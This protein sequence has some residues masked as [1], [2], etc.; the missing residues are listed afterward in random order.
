MADVRIGEPRTYN[1]GNGST[2]VIPIRPPPQ[3]ASSTVRG[4]RDIMRARNERDAKR[5]EEQERIEREGQRARI[6]TQTVE[7]RQKSEAQWLSRPPEYNNNNGAGMRGVPGPANDDGSASILRNIS[8]NAQKEDRRRMSIGPAPRAT[9]GN[10]S[11]EDRSGFSMAQPTRSV[12]ANAAG[13]PQNIIQG[14]GASDVGGP[15]RTKG[16]SK[17]GF[18]LAFERWEELSAHWEG[19][20]SHSLRTIQANL[21]EIESDSISEQ[22]ARQVKDLS[23]AGANL[24]HA[25]VELQRLR[26]SSER[27]FQRWFADTRDEQEKSREITKELE[28]QLQ[29]ERTA[30][31]HTQ[32]KAALETS[33]AEAAELKKQVAEARRELI[34]SRDESRRAWEELGRR[35]QLERERL[36]NLRDGQPTN[37]CGVT[38]VP[39]MDDVPPRRTSI[40]EPAQT[41]ADTSHN[42]RP[43]AREGLYPG[44]PGQSALGGQGMM[45]SP[46][47]GYPESYT[48]SNVTD[49]FRGIAPAY[50][51]S[52]PISPAYYQPSSGG[53]SQ[54][55]QPVY[56][57]S[58]ND[59][60]AS[61]GQA[62]FD[63]LHPAYYQQTATRDNDSDEDEDFD[64]TADRA[65]EIALG[66]DYGFAPSGLGLDAHQGEEVSYPVENYST[67]WESLPRHHNPTTLSAVMEEDE[68]SRTSASQMS[69]R[70]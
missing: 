23:A 65:R 63:Q 68:R 27:K 62:R 55:P 61:P 11:A 51:T 12:N 43:Q 42:E 41:H 45:Q 58:A 36:I 19:I 64:A 20:T 17:T 53:M 37:I 38:V 54:R 6:N 26:A 47:Q 9:R 8:D 13:K 18:P 50:Q 7:D 2:G 32:D 28:A 31:A 70:D 57:S 39:R 49:P 48:E 40:S 29:H 14:D 3:E 1:S 4:P 25:V 24:F 5:K 59:S 67:G 66:Q 33:V 60:R 69:R 21:R 10:E 22:L 30:R 15:V 52:Q 16:A 34:I 56:I 35:E 46:Q 44:G